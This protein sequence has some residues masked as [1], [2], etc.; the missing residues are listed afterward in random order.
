[1]SRHHN[2]RSL[3]IIRVEDGLAATDDALLNLLRDGVRLC[4]LANKLSPNSISIIYANTA[5]KF[6]CVENLK[7]FLGVCVAPRHG[8][9]LPSPSYR[10]PHFLC[11]RTVSLFVM[12]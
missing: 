7:S 6:K 3:D 2:N 11:V 12:S 5:F 4:E 1:M 8:E 10:V 9:R